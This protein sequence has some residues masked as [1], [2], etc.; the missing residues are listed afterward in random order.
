M[1]HQLLVVVGPQHVTV[2]Q[3]GRRQQRSHTQNTHRA[4][5]ASGSGACCAASTLVYVINKSG[6]I[7]PAPSIK[8]VP[9]LHNGIH[10]ILAV[11][12]WLIHVRQ[13]C[14]YVLG[15]FVHSW[16]QQHMVCISGA[17]EDV[18]MLKSMIVFFI[19]LIV[20]LQELDTFHCFQVCPQVPL[21]LG[22]FSL[23]SK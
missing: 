3:Q 13:A 2:L 14:L 18:C 11:P 21:Q 9:H 4:W 15:G 1:I 12:V 22:A 7:T 8:R 19:W 6:I 17:S 5:A 10:F 23:R 16:W 20:D